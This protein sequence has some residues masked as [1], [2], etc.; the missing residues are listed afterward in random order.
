MSSAVSPAV[1]VQTAADLFE[2]KLEDV[3]SSS[4]I[5]GVENMIFSVV[6]VLYAS[7]RGVLKSL[8][9]VANL[10]AEAA[11]APLESAKGAGRRNRPSH[12]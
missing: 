6:R 11:N 8:S 10:T 5:G 9:A 1:A 7:P 12:L 3:N 4:L 2:P